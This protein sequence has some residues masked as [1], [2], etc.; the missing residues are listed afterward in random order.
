MVIDLKAYAEEIQAELQQ[1]RADL[2]LL[3]REM[4]IGERQGK[5]PLAGRH[6]RDDRAQEVLNLDL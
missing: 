5:R 3:R 4:T 1:L 6:A 2:A